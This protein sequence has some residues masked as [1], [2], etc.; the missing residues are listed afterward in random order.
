MVFSSKKALQEAI[1]AQ[2]I[3]SDEQAIKAML[4]IYEYQTRTEQM[5]GYTSED[6]GVGF[7]GV[8]GEILSSFSR[9]YEAKG[10]LSVKQLA[11]LKKKIGKYAGQ[12]VSH[13]IANG[14]YVKVGGYWQ[15]AA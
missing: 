2:I 9:Q 13:A 3:S 11:I 1:K 10:Y 15:V 4:R 8:D 6:N 5:R 14:I 12:L 7:A